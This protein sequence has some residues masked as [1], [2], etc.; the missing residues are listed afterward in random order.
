[1]S[2]ASQILRGAKGSGFDPVLYS[3]HESGIAPLTSAVSNS[4]PIKSH[5]LPSLVLHSTINNKL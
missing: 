4:S 5:E 1:M 2:F 3:E